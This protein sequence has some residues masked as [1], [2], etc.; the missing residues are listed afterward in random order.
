MS[1]L[2]VA[3]APDLAARL[4]AV[5]ARHLG[6]TGELRGLAA[7]TG[8]A[9]KQT[10][11]FE[12]RVGD[13]W[14]PFILQLS[15]DVGDRAASFTPKLDAAADARL[16]RSAAAAGVRV[17]EVMAILDV[18]DGL[19]GGHVTRRIAGETIGRRIVHHA[20][21]AAARDA[22]PAQLGQ[23][24]A[25][26]H[27]IPLSAHPELADFGAAR[28]IA[29]YA[30][31]VDHYGVLSP[32]L[33]HALAWCRAHAPTSHATTVVHGDFRMGNL[34]VD[35][36]GLAGVLDWEAA[37]TGD[38]MQDLGYLC[39]RSWRFGGSAPVAGVASRE[40]LCAAYEAAGGARVDLQAVRFW[41]AWGNVKWAL[42]ALRKGL[43][44][45]D[46]TGAPTSMEQCAIGRRT[47]EPLWD[48]LQ[49]LK[50]TTR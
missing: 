40:A 30:G 7:I 49:L 47:K 12:A 3:T 35:A 50:E 36:Q 5:A 15:S 27:R 44:H 19:G 1:A 33:E 14:L 48:F 29:S 10:Y 17:P 31:I 6:G 32:T 38:P 39:V 28:Q 13:A 37:H 24:L 34:I 18:E 43:R 2:W 45:R 9:T 42:A 21:F 8:G 25:G 46:G 16:M 11:A 41:E 26:V 23:A 4:Q 22:L 20:G